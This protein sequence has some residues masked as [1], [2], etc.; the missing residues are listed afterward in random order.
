M[1][2]FDH[3]KFEKVSLESN[4]DHV[5]DLNAKGYNVNLPLND[6]SLNLLNL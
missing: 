2:R 1:H 6:V 3:G 4:F 5:G